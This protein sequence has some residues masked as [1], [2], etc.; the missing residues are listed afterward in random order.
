MT[1]FCLLKL[2]SFQDREQYY[3]TSTTVNHDPIKISDA[4][5]WLWATDLLYWKQIWHNKFPLN[6][7][8]VPNLS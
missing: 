7:G 3:K 2:Y 5:I 1:E 4:L 6:D 8:S